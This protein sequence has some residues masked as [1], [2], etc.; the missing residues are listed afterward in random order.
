MTEL[1]LSLPPHRYTQ[2]ILMGDL[3]DGPWWVR[4]YVDDL[5]AT[6]GSACY[7]ER[8]PA[9]VIQRNT[10]MICR[11]ARRLLGLPSPLLGPPT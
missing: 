7:F 4:A 2:I 5:S 10:E 9:A 6:E 8:E 1:N 11:A 3:Y